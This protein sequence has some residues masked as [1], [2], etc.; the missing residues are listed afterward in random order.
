RWFY[1]SDRETIKRALSEEE[2][3]MEWAKRLIRER[4]RSKEELLPLPALPRGAAHLAAGLRYTE[5]NIAEGKCAVCPK[6][7][8]RN[9]VRFCTKH[10][11]AARLRYKPI[12]SA[13]PGSIDFLYADADQLQSRHGR[14]PGTLSSLA[15]AREQ[16]TRAILAELGFSPESAAVSLK[17]AK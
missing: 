6:P 17:A 3:P 11:R 13:P 9:S 15:M 10:L 2:S 12:G 8:D 5:R 7:L 1:E 14:Q 16:K 4:G